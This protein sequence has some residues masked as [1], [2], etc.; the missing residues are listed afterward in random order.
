MGLTSIQVKYYDQEERED[1]G[2]WSE[3]EVQWTMMKSRQMTYI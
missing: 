2:S 3:L 1:M